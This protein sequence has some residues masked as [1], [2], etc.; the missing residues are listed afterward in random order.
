MELY[1]V[2]CCSVPVVVVMHDVREMVCCSRVRTALLALY[3]LTSSRISCKG[4]VAMKD[5]RAG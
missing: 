4:L 1:S 2:C 5:F 3:H